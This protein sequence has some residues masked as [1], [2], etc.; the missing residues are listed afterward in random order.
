MKKDKKNELDTGVSL[1][2]PGVE[3]KG[4]ISTSGSVRVDG[5]V[6]GNIKADGVITIGERGEVKG[7]LKA[8]SIIIGGTVTGTIYAQER[9]QL[10]SQAQVEGDLFASKLIVE[11]GA[12]FVGKS[13]MNQAKD[14]RDGH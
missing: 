12:R 1:I 4:D 6:T 9:L 13:S 5:K 8:A 3:I 11:E 14:D 10:E 2:S 7:D